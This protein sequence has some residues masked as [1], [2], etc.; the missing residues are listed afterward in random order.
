MGNLRDTTGPSFNIPGKY[1]QGR[2]VV[3]HKVAMPQWLAMLTQGNNYKTID[4]AT[5]ESWPAKGTDDY[6]SLL[7]LYAAWVDRYGYD[8]LE[9][10]GNISKQRNANLDVLNPYSITAG[11]Q[12]H[13]RLLFAAADYEYTKQVAASRTGMI[14][15][16]FNPYIVPGYPMDV[17]ADS[18][19]DPTFH[20]LCASVTH[21]ISSRSIGTSIGM[22][23]A[24]TYSELSNY[25]IPPLHPWLQ[26]ALGLINVDWNSSSTSGSQSATTGSG[27][28]VAFNSSSTSS[29]PPTSDQQEYGDVSNASSVQATL[30]N[31]PKGKAAADQFY[32]SVFGIGAVAP[33]DIYNFTN[34]QSIP[35]ARASGVWSVGSNS[36]K[37]TANGGDSNDF[38]TAVGNLRLV[39]RPIEGRQAIE[40]KFG[41]KFIDMTPQNYTPTGASYQNPL[42]SKDI[43]LEPGASLFLDYEETTSFISP[44]AQNEAGS[45]SSKLPPTSQ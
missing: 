30:I 11:I 26:T 10:D 3:H 19:N 22:V 31:N 4:N 16:I 29:T 24:S 20:G 39:S 42:L 41:V 13:E 12:P 15:A 8:I 43:L 45:N 37:S 33:D 7:N 2:G 1:E 35:I 6:N 27:A 18:P 38:N 23:A 17:L 25:Y 5:Q 32:Q 21:S 34:G 44:A 36:P 40:N 9:N 14:D 28:P